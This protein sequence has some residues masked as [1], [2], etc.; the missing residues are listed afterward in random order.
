MQI[1]NSYILCFKTTLAPHTY[2]VMSSGLRKIATGIRESNFMGIFLTSSLIEPALYRLEWTKTR[3]STRTSCPCENEKR[4]IVR[5]SGVKHLHGYRRPEV[6]KNASSSSSAAVLRYDVI[7]TIIMCANAIARNPFHV[8]T[9]FF[10]ELFTLYI[11][12]F[13]SNHK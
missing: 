8:N 4:F 13:N 3:C 5:L 12:I 7:R 6:R 11:I 9:D 10:P 1:C 2:I